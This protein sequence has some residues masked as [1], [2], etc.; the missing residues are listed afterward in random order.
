MYALSRFYDRNSYNPFRE[1]EELSRNFWR[2][3]NQTFSMDI[4][5]Q[6][7]SYEFSADLP[8][9]NKDDIHLDLDGD[10][11]TISAERHSEYEEKNENTGFIRMERSF[12]SFSRSLDVSQVDTTGISA[13][14]EDGVLKLHMPKKAETVPTS[15][16]IEIA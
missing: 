3:D 11:L 7:D 1:M 5:D 9:M 16:R 12:G 8:G 4:V 6:G 13:K 15:H 2:N 14:Y 10:V